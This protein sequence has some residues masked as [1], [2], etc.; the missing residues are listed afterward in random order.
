MIFLKWLFFI[1]WIIVC[2]CVYVYVEERKKYELDRRTDSSSSGGGASLCL[3]TVHWTTAPPLS[4]S[5]AAGWH[6]CMKDVLDRTDNTFLI[7]EVI[8]S[9]QNASGPAGELVCGLAAGV[10]L[11]TLSAKKI[12]SASCQNINSLIASW[13]SF[14][15]KVLLIIQFNKHLL[16]DS[17][18]NNFRIP[19][20]GNSFASYPV[21]TYNSIK[22][23]K[24]HRQK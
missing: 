13:L 8:S 15:K 4:P 17:S 1:A 21:H 6:Y 24:T 16:T 19:K 23:S 3:H 2:Q 11:Q 9:T 20:K 18:R 14:L 12:Y 10:N 5:P 7:T 22:S